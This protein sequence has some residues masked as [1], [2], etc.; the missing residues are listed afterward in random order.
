MTDVPR[1]SPERLIIWSSGRPATV[2]RRR[3]MD[4]PI[5]NF[6][7]FVFPVKN[8]NRYVKLQSLHL[9]STFFIKLSFFFCWSPEVPL[10][11]PD[12]RIF[13]GPSWDVPGTSRAGWDCSNI[14]CRISY[15]IRLFR[16][17]QS[18]LCLTSLKGT[19]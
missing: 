17:Y 14:F 3:P 1:T 19:S 18:L 7:I 16:E 2:S 8:S 15:E 6:C 12:V 11:V 5:N 10:E 13:R 9:K 4:V